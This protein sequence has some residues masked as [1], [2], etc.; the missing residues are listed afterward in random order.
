MPDAVHF[1]PFSIWIDADACPRGIRDLIFRAA[2]RLRLRCTLVAN[3]YMA[4]P[5]SEYIAFELVPHGADKA[6]DHI[7]AHASGRDIVVTGD[8]PLAARLI[9]NGILVLN[10]RGEEWTAANIG[11]R[12]AMR[13]LMEGLRSAGLTTGGP[14]ELDQTDVRRFANALDRALTKRRKEASP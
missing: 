13:N 10:T 11:E 6:D 12:L 7:V 5:G 14:K 9:E 3:T 4:L 2:V 8:I 1:S